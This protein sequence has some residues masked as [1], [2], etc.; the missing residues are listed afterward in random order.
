MKNENKFLQID[1]RLFELGLSSTEVLTLAYIK[2]YNDNGK[3]FYASNK[4]IANQLGLTE[5]A[6]SRAIKTIS[7]FKAV[8][9]KGAKGRN[10][11]IQ[12]NGEINALEINDTKTPETK[13]SPTAETIKTSKEE[14]MEKYNRTDVVDV[15]EYLPSLGFTNNDIFKIRD[16]LNN[17]N[18]MI[19]DIIG[20]IGGYI[21]EMKYN[22]YNG[23]AITNEIKNNIKLSI[24]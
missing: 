14:D 4:F 22:D 24:L 13:E 5:K 7:K 2:S 17:D 23:P 6:V 1:Y 16:R 12:I 11:S 15:Y 3:T 10:R 18:V 8:T 21:K 20:V 19:N 9:I